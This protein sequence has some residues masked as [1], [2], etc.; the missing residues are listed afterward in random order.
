MVYLTIR[1]RARDS[2]EVI[3]LIEIESDLIVLVE[4]ETKHK[5]LYTNIEKTRAGSHFFNKNAP[6]K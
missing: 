2:Y 5:I 4:S 6:G 3:E 1:L